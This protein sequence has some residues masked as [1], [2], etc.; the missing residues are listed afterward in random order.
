MRKAF[1]LLLLLSASAMV[2]SAQTQDWSKF[3]SP[4]G[5]FS[6]QVPAAPVRETKTHTDAK[7]G[8]F[9][10][11][12]YIA[13]ADREIYVFGW[14]D[15]APTFKFDVRGELEANRDKFLAGI[16]AKLLDTTTVTLGKHQGIEFTAELPN[17]AIKSRVYVVGR[18]PYQLIVITPA[19]RDATQNVTRFLTSF[20]LTPPK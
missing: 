19:G 2:V 13:R 14:V 9:T 18:R 7:V 10:T 16:K 17:A 5:G 3:T 12:L 6:I 1:P 20:E 15:Y 8:E 4:E 11:N